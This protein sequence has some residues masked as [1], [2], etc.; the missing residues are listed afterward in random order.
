MVKIL[1]SG[2]MRGADGHRGHKQN[3]GACLEGETDF[4][5]DTVLTVMQYQL[6]TLSIFKG[7]WYSSLFHYISSRAIVEADFA[8]VRV[9]LHKLDS[10]ALF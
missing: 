3:R 10:L 8:P 1:L 4:V 5:S 7:I 6:S 2:G 9:Q